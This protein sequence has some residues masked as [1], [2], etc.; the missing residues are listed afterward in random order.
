LIVKGQIE[1]VSD[2]SKTMLRVPVKPGDAPGER[3]A[4]RDVLAYIAGKLSPADCPYRVGG[5]YG[6]QPNAVSEAVLDITVTAVRQERLGDI[7]DD[8]VRREGHR[9]AWQFFNH[10]RRVHGDVKRDLSAVHDLRALYADVQVWVI[11]FEREHERKPVFLGKRVGYTTN[12]RGAMQDDDRDALGRR[13]PIE[14]VR[15]SE[16]AE[17]NSVDSRLRQRL[18]AQYEGVEPEDVLALEGG[19]K[20]TKA[21]ERARRQL[22]RRAIDGLPQ[23]TTAQEERTLAYMVRNG[24][25]VRDVARALD[26]SVGLAHKLIRQAKQELDAA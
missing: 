22:G 16:L 8:D 19:W 24:R 3:G 21:I 9:T 26:C 14:A 23:L 12:S 11:T 1:K 4:A 25:S 13:A 6:V 18:V 10:W 5:T 17:L 7:S 15:P 20:T 2:G